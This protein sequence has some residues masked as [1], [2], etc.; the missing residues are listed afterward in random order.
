MALASALLST[1][2]GAPPEGAVMMVGSLLI[3]VGAL[4]IG[5]V[6]PVPPP[7]L[8]LV[9]VLVAPPL[10]DLDDRSANQAAQ[11]CNWPLGGR[12]CSSRIQSAERGPIV[13]A[14]SFS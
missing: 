6:P 7:P 13:F 12:H 9:V 4:W 3:T 2:A 11:L 1:V 10:D 14:F 5:G 8:P